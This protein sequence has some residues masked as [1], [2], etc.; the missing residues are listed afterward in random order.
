MNATGPLKWK[1]RTDDREYV[2]VKV[3][4]PS[5]HETSS[6]KP[7]TKPHET[8]TKPLTN[9]S[10][11]LW[12]VHET[13]GEYRFAIGQSRRRSDYERWL[14][15]LIA[16]T[17]VLVIEE[18]TSRHYAGI[19]A[20]LKKAGRPIPSNDLWIAA[21]CRQHRLPLLSQDRHFDAV[22]GLDRV[23]W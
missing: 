12:R 14:R 20:A 16:A 6:T 7:L 4:V 17:R 18:E 1:E 10:R 8:S 22:E 9:L 5:V 13:S 3:S 23:A 11:N 21:L 19:R 2:F 15:E